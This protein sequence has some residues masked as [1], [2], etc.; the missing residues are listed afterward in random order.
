LTT[1]RLTRADA[2][3]SV[4]RAWTRHEMLGLLDR[5]GLRPVAEAGGF[6]GHRYAIAAVR[7]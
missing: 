1:N 5:A 7:R 3:M 6:L 2:P 4:R